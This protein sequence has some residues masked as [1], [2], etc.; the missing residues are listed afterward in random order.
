MRRS[1]RRRSNRDPIDHGRLSQRPN[2]HHPIRLYDCDVPCDG[3]IAV[4][5]SAVDV[6]KDMPKQPV[7]FE[8]VGTQ[9]IERTTGI[10]PR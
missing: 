2:D 10:R 5:V 1:T 3:A 8:A 4:V 9:I 6:A 7:L